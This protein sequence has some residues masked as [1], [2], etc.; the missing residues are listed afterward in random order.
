MKDFDESK[1]IVKARVNEQWKK[2]FKEE[3]EVNWIEGC[4]LIANNK[5]DYFKYR[6]QPVIDSQRYAFPIN[7]E[8]ICKPTGQKDKDNCLIFEHD[9]C[10]VEN[11]GTVLFEVLWNDKTSGYILKGDDISLDFRSI[12]GNQCTV[13]GNAFDKQKIQ[14]DRKDMGRTLF[15]GDK[16]Q[17]E[18]KDWLKS[19]AKLGTVYATF[20][21][22]SK[23][24]ILIF[25]NQQTADVWFSDGVRIADATLDEVSK[26]L[27]KMSLNKE[28]EEV[29]EE[30]EYTL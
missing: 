2:D 7:P 16:G 22:G 19:N 12:Y 28:N 9:L 20:E 8:T 18:I 23:A 24:T 27:V 1:Y 14:K 21:D 11:F 3:N 13:I 5:K 25:R 17:E 15:V 4:L 30:T 29:E 6:I 26:E 10:T